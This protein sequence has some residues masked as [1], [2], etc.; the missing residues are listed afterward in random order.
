[1]QDGDYVDVTG[2]Y[3]DDRTQ[4]V[5]R[6][7]KQSREVELRENVETELQGYVD[8]FR[9]SDQF[10]V[11]GV[12]IDASQA[13]F[14]GGRANDLKNGTRITVEGSIKDGVLFA[15]EIYFSGAPSTPGAAAAATVEIEGVISKFNSLA[16]FVVKGVHIDASAASVKGAGKH[17]PMA[18][19]KAHAKGTVGADGVVK[20]TSLEFD[21]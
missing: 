18:G 2:I 7:V 21:R 3:V 6:E 12:T 11:A 13:S 19:W 16:D 20:A 14:F 4:L 1:M 15:E 9:G 5:A 8:N 17:T 10:I